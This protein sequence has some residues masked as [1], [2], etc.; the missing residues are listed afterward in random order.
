MQKCKLIK[1]INF[2]SV[3]YSFIYFLHHICERRRR[4]WMCTGS[5]GC[6]S[7]PSSIRTAQ[8]P[9]SHSCLNSTSTW[10]WT[11]TAP[12]KTTSAPPTAWRSFQVSQ[13]I[14]VT[15]A[16]S[17]CE[18]WPWAVVCVTL[19]LVCH[20]MFVSQVTRTHSLSSQP[21]SPNTSLIRASLAL[22]RTLQLFI[23]FD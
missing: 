18:L 16:A 8:A 7:A 9:C 21:F 19:M 20:V 4:C 12:S 22:V 6:V 2:K 13:L 3:I 1:L 10:S 15:R 14:L 11:A 5:W 17:V 23:C